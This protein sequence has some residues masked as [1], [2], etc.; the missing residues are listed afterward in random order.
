MK[1]YEPEPAEVYRIAITQAKA[2]TIRL[3]VTDIE[4]VEQG[5]QIVQEL[6]MLETSPFPEGPRTTVEIRRS[7]GGANFESAKASFYGLAPERVKQIILAY[8][9]HMEDV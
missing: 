5:K 3:T 9:T 1:L 4:S 2:P 8:I 6:V 7:K